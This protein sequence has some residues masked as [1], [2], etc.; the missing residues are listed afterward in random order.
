MYG[1]YVGYRSF[2]QVMITIAQWNIAKKMVC[3]SYGLVFGVN[4]F[5]ALILQSLL[6]RIVTDSRGLGLQVKEAFLVY[7]CLHAIISII[8]LSVVIYNIVNYFLAKRKINDAPA[9]S[10]APISPDRKSRS[11]SISRKVT[12]VPEATNTIAMTPL[13]PS[14]PS[15]AAPALEIAPEL[16]YSSSDDDFNSDYEDE[17][18]DIVPVFLR[19]GMASE[20]MAANFSA[21]FSNK[22]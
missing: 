20:S 6:T 4:S 5:I 16:D 7:A 12:V 17:Q 22:A 18:T 15:S 19:S 14:A 21:S 9:A 13:G 1:C 11:V 8:F 3:D 10:P 2:Y